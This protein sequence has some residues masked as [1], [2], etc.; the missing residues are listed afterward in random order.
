M[1][2][3]TIINSVHRLL[4]DIM[5]IIIAL[6]CISPGII[7]YCMLLTSAYPL[8]IIVSLLFFMLFWVMLSLML[9]NSNKLIQLYLKIRGG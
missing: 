4:A 2:T 8:N 9:D 7:G 5:L 1:I 6:L 3:K